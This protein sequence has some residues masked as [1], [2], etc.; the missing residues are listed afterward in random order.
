MA[1]NMDTVCNVITWHIRF[2]VSVFCQ[3]N[4]KMLA[5]LNTWC[6]K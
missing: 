2:S 3:R 6:T 1:L 4:T 5:Q